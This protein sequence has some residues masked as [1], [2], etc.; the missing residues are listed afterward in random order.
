MKLEA[1]RKARHDAEA[2]QKALVQKAKEVAELTVKL[3]GERKARHDTEAA[4][5]KAENEEKDSQADYSGN[6]DCIFSMLQ[7]SWRQTQSW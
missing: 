5:K 1:E 6:L 3:E 4:H 7:R 2:D